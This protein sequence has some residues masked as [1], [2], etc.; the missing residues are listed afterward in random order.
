MSQPPTP[1]TA[2]LDQ[3]TADLHQ[4]QRTVTERFRPLTDQQLNRRPTP[5]RWSVGQCLEHLNI[6]GGYYLPLLTAK[7]QKAR[8]RG[9]APAATVKRGLVGR[10]LTAAVRAPAGEKT[11]KSPQKYAPSGSR[12]PRTVVDVC[13]RQLDD[14]L[15]LV[16]EARHVNLNAVRVANPVI[17]LLRLRATDTLEMLVVHAQRHVAQAERVLGG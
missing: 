1:T 12:L 6:M 14:L 4:L 13:R 11:Y 2:L 9:S 7:M 8:Q 3:L 5:G 16:E 10:R 15:Q 17:P